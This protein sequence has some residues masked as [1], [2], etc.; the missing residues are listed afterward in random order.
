MDQIIGIILK[1]IPIAI[2]MGVILWL[3][4]RKEKISNLEERK[5]YGDFTP[6]GQ[7]SIRKNARLLL[8]PI[9]EKFAI[10]SP[11]GTKVFCNQDI[12]K[13]EIIEYGKPILTKQSKAQELTQT[14]LRNIVPEVDLGKGRKGSKICSKLVLKIDMKDDYIIEEISNQDIL[15]DSIEY[16]QIKERA[17][18]IVQT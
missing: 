5:E 6:K 12:R 11:Q 13:C 7:I 14:L 16:Q 9:H 4:N 1:V 17:D 10:V 3:M 18:R 8:D 15:K 2:C